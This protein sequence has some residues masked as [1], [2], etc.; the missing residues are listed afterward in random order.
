MWSFDLWHSNGF[1][2]LAELYLG[3]VPKERAADTR[4][5]DENGDLVVSN[6]ALS[7]PLRLPLAAALRRPSWLDPATR[8]VLL[9]R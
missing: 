2:A 8:S 3:R 4:R 5:I 7:A 6:P 9:G 1:A